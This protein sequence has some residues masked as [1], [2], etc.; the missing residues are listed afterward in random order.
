ML[1]NYVMLP[2]RRENIYINVFIHKKTQT[3]V[4]LTVRVLLE[5]FT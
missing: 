3:V 1:T 2:T 5:T 4:H